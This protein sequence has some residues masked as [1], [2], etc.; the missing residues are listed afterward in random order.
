ML[1]KATTGKKMR[2]KMIVQS[3]KK[4]LWKS[5]LRTKSSMTSLSMG[6]DYT[7]CA[8]TGIQ[9]TA[10]PSSQSKIF[11]TTSSSSAVEDKTVVDV[12]ISEPGSLK[13]RK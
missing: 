9:Q 7:V 8:G 12:S 2:F 6:T 3:Y 4:P 10:I 1:L 11:L 5:M 13:L